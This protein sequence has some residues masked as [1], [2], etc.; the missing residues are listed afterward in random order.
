M[1]AGWAGFA[2]IFAGYGI[3][4]RFA[5]CTS[6]LQVVDGCQQIWALGPNSQGGEGEKEEKEGTRPVWTG[7]VARL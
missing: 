4:V 2:K 6:V 5:G 3:F 7:H 1:F